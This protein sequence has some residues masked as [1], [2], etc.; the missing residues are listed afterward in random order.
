MEMRDTGRQKNI[1]KERRAI[2]ITERKAEIGK[3]EE[4]CQRLVERKKREE[5]RNEG[6]S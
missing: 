3:Q 2:K 5:R 1:E 4:G 6:R